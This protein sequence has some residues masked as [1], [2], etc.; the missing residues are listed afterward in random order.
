[1]SVTPGPP[2]VG[3]CLLSGLLDQRAG[4]GSVPPGPR[5]AGLPLACPPACPPLVLR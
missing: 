5:A 4:S 3:L 2:A 1:M